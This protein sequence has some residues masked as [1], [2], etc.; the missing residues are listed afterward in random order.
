[1]NPSLFH[2][3][4]MNQLPLA[5]Y[6]VAALGV[7]LFLRGLQ[8]FSRKR[9]RGHVPNVSVSS[10]TAGPATITGA[11]YGMR[12]LTTPITGKE[13]F[14]YRAS[15]WQKESG[16]QEWKNVAEETGH[17]TFLVED[18]T[19]KLSVEPCGAELVLRS[20]FNEEYAS[21]S[22]SPSNEA[23]TPAAIPK[24]VGSFLLRNGVAPD[25]PTRIEE[26]CLPAGA[27]VFVTGTLIENVD[28]QKDE[29]GGSPVIEGADRAAPRSQ[30]E[31]M[32]NPSLPV[33]ASGPEV[34][35]LASGTTPS[36]TLQMTQQAKIA[37]ALNRAGLAKPDLWTPAE[38]HVPNV[39]SVVVTEKAQSDPSL[40][41]RALA[42]PSPIDVL[43][44]RG[45]SRDSSPPRFTMTKGAEGSIFIIS[46]HEPVLPTVLGWQSV[47]LV[48][49][50]STL[51]TLGIG[52]LLLGHL[53]RVQ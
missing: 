36:T 39:S 3:I 51:A 33:L 22:P 13:C 6:G 34:I 23:S 20:S 52:A 19:G 26:C 17:L 30:A 43:P 4:A 9:S 47:A 27:P 45:S 5:A 8:L 48:I 2:F 1:V 35:R 37:A 18:P 29:M 46:N 7:C 14:V 40:T 53:H 16:S 32:A 38:T 49:L 50:G 11:A 28:P 41:M 31:P 44:E 15:I 12:K 10:A 25:R 42:S 24:N 21:P